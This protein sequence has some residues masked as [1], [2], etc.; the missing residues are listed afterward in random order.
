V[1]KIRL[2]RSGVKNKPYFRIVVIDKRRKR[3]GKPLDILGYWQP[4]KEDIRAKFTDKGV[5]QIDKNKVKYW[6][7]RG[8]KTSRVVD[9]LLRNK[10]S[11]S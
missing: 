8:A 5:R 6:I 1:L 9:K 11:V 3:G 7:E 2:A 4:V 10:N